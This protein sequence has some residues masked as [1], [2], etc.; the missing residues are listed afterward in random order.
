MRVWTIIPARGGSKSIPLKNLVS[1]SGM[2]LIDYSILSTQAAK[3]SERIVCSTDSLKIAERCYHHKIE[4]DI[5]P[6]ALGEDD[7]PVND[8][9]HD[10]FNRQEEL[11]DLCLLVQPTSPFLLPEHIITLVESVKKTIKSLSGQTICACPHNYHAINQR[12]VSNGY[13]DFCFKEARL[14]AY[15]KQKKKKH[16]LFGNLLCFKPEAL[17]KYNNLFAEPSVAVEIPHAYAF[18]LDMPQ[19]IKM[20]ESYIKMNIVELPHLD[21][22]KR[23]TVRSE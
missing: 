13:V 19:D 15:N 1:V 10:F 14:A 20:A 8:V 16:Y 21:A 22:A 17:L 12:V 2:P 5:R 3:V 4:V 18:D 11:P 23:L 7:T 9:L 6:E